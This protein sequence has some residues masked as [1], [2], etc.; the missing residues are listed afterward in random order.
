MSVHD[1]KRKILLQ[2][3][4]HGIIRIAELSPLFGVSDETIRKDLDLLSQEGK[5]QRTHGG[6]ISIS[7]PHSLTPHLEREFTN[8][9][10]KIAIAEMALKHIQPHDTIAI[11]G[12]TS[13]FYLA[14]IIPDI[15]LTILTNSMKVVFELSNRENINLITVG[16][17]L[18]RKSYSFHGALT[19]RILKEYHV[20]KAFLSCTGL[21]IE[22]GFS[23]SNEAH[24]SVKQRM[25]E[26][27]DLVYFLVDSS[28][29][30]VKDLVQIA[31]ISDI[32]YVITDGQADTAGYISKLREA[33]LEIIDQ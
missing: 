29:L 3:K 7:E 1:R 13:V 15:P 23:D 26:I 2:L 12:S 20:N 18:L 32:D 14:K 16:G 33:Q 5:L 17:N 19:E 25:I 28:K 6:A 24:A 8:V 4:Q 22:R 30:G 11:D 27:A 31:P 9:E 21:H 10:H